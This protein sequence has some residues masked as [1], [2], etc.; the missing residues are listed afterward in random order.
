MRD[1]L[2]A[3]GDRSPRGLQQSAGMMIN[4]VYKLAEI[5]DN[6]ETYTS[7]GRIAADSAVKGLVKS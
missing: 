3:R 7:K 4:Y 5:D 6:H 1:S 2:R